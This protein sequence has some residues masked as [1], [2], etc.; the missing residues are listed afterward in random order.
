VFPSWLRVLVV[1]RGAR[2]PICGGMALATNAKTQDTKL[3]MGLAGLGAA[4]THILRAL[5]AY[6]NIVVT[7]ACDVR[8]D[9]LAAFR[10]TRGGQTYSSVEQMAGSDEVDAVYVATP[11]YLHGEHVM[12]AIANRKDVIVEKP[13]A[14]TLEE[15]D[16]MIKGAADA[17]VRVLAGHTHSFDAPIAAMARL[18]HEDG[19]IGDLYMLHN[20]YYTDWMYRGRVPDELDTPR[21]GGVVFRQGP[22]GID[23]I[24]QLAG[25]KATRVTARTSQ[26]DPQHATHGSYTAMI[27]FGPKVVATVTFSGY[28]YFDSSELTWGR[29]E[30]GCPRPTGTSSENR[31]R[32]LGFKTAEEETAYKNSVRFTGPEAENWLSVLDC[33]EEIRTHP[34]YGLT[35]ASGSKGDLRQSEHG[36]YFYGNDGRVEIPVAKAAL[37]RE[38]EL[39]VLYKAWRD[40]VPL[41]GHDAVWARDT[42]EICLAIIESSDTGRAVDLQ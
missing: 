38:A 19:L 11:N 23:V 20:A 9:A 41:A 16:R 37:E 34:F 18:I 32:V 42:L 35:I 12:Q 10:A 2:T 6:E 30:L 40:G 8:E 39:D 1:L 4:S 13:I 33:D 17:G 31:R 36:V 29:G 5:D 22:H 27:E 15:C 24:R 28:G 3:R 14:V 21:G 26:L 7:A 25:Q